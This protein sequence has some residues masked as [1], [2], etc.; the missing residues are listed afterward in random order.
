[1][2]AQNAD[3]GYGAD[4]EGAGDG[5]ARFVG[6][7]TAG[8]VDGI[9][10]GQRAASQDIFEFSREKAVAAIRRDRADR[11]DGSVERCDRGSGR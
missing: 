5:G 3:E 2:A 1:M 6:V 11:G 9:G 10:L 4:A 7:E 8:G